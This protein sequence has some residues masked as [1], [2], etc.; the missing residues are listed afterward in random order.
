[1]IRQEYPIH[2]YLQLCMHLNAEALKDFPYC[3]ENNK[4]FKFHHYYQHQYIPAR[5]GIAM[6]SMNF[7][8]KFSTVD[9]E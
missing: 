3:D 9:N 5:F 2:S 7:S 8:G 6:N 4:V 1:M